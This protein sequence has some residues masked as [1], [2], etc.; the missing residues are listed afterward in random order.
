MEAA[1]FAA[2]ASWAARTVTVCAVSQLD[3]LKVSVARSTVTSG[4]PLMVTPI[5]TLEAGC[6]FSLTV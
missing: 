3:G 6:V 5:T 1:S 2:S 4:L